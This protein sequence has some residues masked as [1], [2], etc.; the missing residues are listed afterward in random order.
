MLVLN[1]KDKEKLCK[2]FKKHGLNITIECN[3]W[4][5]NF[6]DV[7]SN[8]GTRKYYPHRKVNNELLYI[9]KQSNHPS[10]TKEIPAMINKRISNISCDKECFDKA[11]PDY[12]NA[13]RN[14]NFNENI[15]FTPRLPN[16]RKLSRNILWFNPPFNSNVKTNTGKYFC[17]S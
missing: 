9:H 16:R 12:N 11:A 8:L 17:N 7:T 2:I 10:I 15:K 6:Q 13:L 1:L 4:I 14:S 5:T 3:L